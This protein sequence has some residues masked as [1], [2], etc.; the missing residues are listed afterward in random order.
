MREAQNHRVA[1]HFNNENKESEG[2]NHTPNHN[3]PENGCHHHDPIKMLLSQP[4]RS[5]LKKSCLLQSRKVENFDID[6]NIREVSDD[7]E[8]MTIIK[9][10]NGKIKLILLGFPRASDTS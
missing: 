3:H 9:L 5:S 8:V 6:M 2:D 1:I 4:K 10:F 7:D